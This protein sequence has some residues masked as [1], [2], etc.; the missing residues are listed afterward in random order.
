MSGDK[1]LRRYSCIWLDFSFFNKAFNK[2]KLFNFVF[3]ANGP[4]GMVKY[5]FVGSSER[6][7]WFP[8]FSFK[9]A[10][11]KKHIR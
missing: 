2:F 5:N 9:G 10:G 1:N 8:E 7:A 3:N 6:L 11:T 4:I